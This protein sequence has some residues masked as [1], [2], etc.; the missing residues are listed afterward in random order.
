MSRKKSAIPKFRSEKEEAKWW[1]A[2]PEVATRLLRKALQ[3]GTV[4]RRLGESRIVTMRIPLRD[5]EAARE[6]ADRKGLP[7]Q[8]YM[9]MLL[10]QA[11][12]KERAAG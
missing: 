1:D 3:Q 4:Q 9:K 10:H 2:H 6:L 8:T 12:E 7:Y 11:P 5:L